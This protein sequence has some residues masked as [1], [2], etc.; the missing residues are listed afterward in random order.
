VVVDAKVKPSP[1]TIARRLTHL[2]EKRQKVCGCWL[3]ERAGIIEHEA[4]VEREKAE[5]MASEDEHVG[6]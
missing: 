3:C 6:K 4:K 1:D 2:A 5:K